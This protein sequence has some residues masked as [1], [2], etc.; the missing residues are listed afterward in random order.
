MGKMNEAE[1]NRKLETDKCKMEI[2]TYK[3]ELSNFVKK[4]QTE[5]IAN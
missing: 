5:A 1:T 2:E 4:Y 3:G